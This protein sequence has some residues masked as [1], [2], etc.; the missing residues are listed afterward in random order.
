MGLFH[1]EHSDLE[2]GNIYFMINVSKMFGTYTIDVSYI[3][4]YMEFFEFFNK[5]FLK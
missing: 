4:E 3:E 2:D 1:I 5:K